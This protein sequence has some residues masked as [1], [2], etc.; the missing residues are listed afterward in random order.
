MVEIG[1][2][3]A[4]HLDNVSDNFRIGLTVYLCQFEQFGKI[5]DVFSCNFLPYLIQVGKFFV[6]LAE[7]DDPVI[8]NQEHLCKTLSV[9]IYALI[10]NSPEVD[11]IILI[12]AELL[13]GLFGVPVIIHPLPVQEG[14][15]C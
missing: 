5:E 8:D 10:F 2:C 14:E 9:L 1:D 13:L 12:G 4:V 6:F 11:Q 3:L 7:T 15:T